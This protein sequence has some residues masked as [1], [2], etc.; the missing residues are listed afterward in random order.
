VTARKHAAPRALSK[1]ATGLRGFDELTRGGLPLNRTS[2]VMG[3][4]GTGKTVFALQVLV[5]AARERQQ[6]GI[7]VA[8]EEHPDQILENAAA[9]GWR[10][11]ELSRN[12][13]FFPQCP[14]LAGRRAVR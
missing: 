7:F 1:V 10:L 13:L 2:L 6:P 11:P 5:N 4:S 9:F 3:S 8:F 14:T 12:A